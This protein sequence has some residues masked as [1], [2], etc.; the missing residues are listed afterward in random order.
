MLVWGGSTS[1]G[2]NAIQ[3]AVAAGYDVITTASPHNADYV[4]GPGAR[5]VFDYRSPDVISDI[6][7][8]L[9]GRRLAGAIAIGT[10]SAPACVRIVA[11]SEG[12]K[13]VAIASP[14][15]SFAPLGEPGRGRL[16]TLGIV[17]RLISSNIRLMVR[18]R[19]RGNTIN[20]RLQGCSLSAGAVRDS[21]WCGTRTVLRIGSR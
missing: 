10:T 12:S 7:A 8:A 20:L 21:R 2:S 6:V 4:R 13:V 5:E 19:V 16:A 18:A 14:P 3:L 1:V 17:R 15:V 11:A 9:Y